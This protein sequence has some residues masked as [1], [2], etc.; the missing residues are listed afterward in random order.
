MK[1]KNLFI[2]KR[3]LPEIEGMYVHSLSIKE[4]SEIN[5]LIEFMNYLE[6]L[7]NW[8]EQPGNYFPQKDRFS[9][10]LTIDD[11][12]LFAFEMTLHNKD[13][14]KLNIIFLSDFDILEFVNSLEIRLVDLNFS[15]IMEAKG[16]PFFELI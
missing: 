1:N 12:S 13:K 11:I 10:D 16:V 2:P 8:S 7:N 5:S 6:V 15:E 9:S 3:I 4:L 14:R